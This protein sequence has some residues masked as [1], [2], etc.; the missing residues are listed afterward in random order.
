MLIDRR[1]TLPI[2]Y[3]RDGRDRW[4]RSR[5]IILYE[6]H[7]RRRVD[8]LFLLPPIAVPDADD[9]LFHL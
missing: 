4:G 8:P 9:F 1:R 5:R 3:R 2:G 6:S 7:R